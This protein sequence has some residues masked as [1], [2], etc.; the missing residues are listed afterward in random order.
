MIDELERLEQAATPTKWKTEMA[1]DG[2]CR[3]FSEDAYVIARLYRFA[4]IDDSGGNENA[5]F[6]AAARN[7]LPAL[8]RVARAALKLS[9]SVAEF[10]ELDSERMDALDAAL[11]ALEA[12]P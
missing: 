9:D 8:L 7:A 6:I 1:V 5:A 4:A 11:A 12:T 3:L 2:T 10:G